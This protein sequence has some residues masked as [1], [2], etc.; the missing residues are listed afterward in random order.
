M[1]AYL[2]DQRRPP[3]RRRGLLCPLPLAYM[4]TGERYGLAP[5][6]IE[7]APADRVAYYLNLMGIEGQAKADMD[8]LKPDE[9]MFWEDEED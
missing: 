6:V 4:Y 3:H 5:W 7:D 8:G 2:D 9:P 1:R